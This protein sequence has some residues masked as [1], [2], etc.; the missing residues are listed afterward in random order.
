MMLLN[1]SNHPLATWTDK[2][3]EA[4]KQQ[5]GTIQDLPFPQVSPNATEDDIQLLAQ[6]YLNKVQQYGSSEQVVVHLMGELNL[7][8]ALVSLLKA[9]GYTCVASTTERVVKELDNHQKL[10][11]FHFVQFRKY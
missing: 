9:N 1:L 3:V 7:T 8:F 11:E 6:A 2:Q 10:A 4:A 5:F